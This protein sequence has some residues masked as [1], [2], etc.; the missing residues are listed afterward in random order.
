MWNVKVPLEAVELNNCMTRS[1][2]RE[3]V[4]VAVARLRRELPWALLQGN[5]SKFR[6]EIGDL[7]DRFPPLIRSR[8]GGSS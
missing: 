7:D 4:V 3:L 5:D 8:N 6:R 2:W 1:S